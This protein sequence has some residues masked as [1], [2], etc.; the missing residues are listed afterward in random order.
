MS[1]TTWTSKYPD[2]FR[3]RCG[4]CETWNPIDKGCC[5]QCKSP[6]NETAQAFRIHNELSPKEDEFYSYTAPMMLESLRM[7][8]TELKTH[9][10]RELILNIDIERLMDE[11]TRLRECIEEQK[12]EDNNEPT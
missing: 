10:G 2:A 12:K 1:P 11:N 3:W 8:L 7:I 9:A 4:R 5:T 6:I